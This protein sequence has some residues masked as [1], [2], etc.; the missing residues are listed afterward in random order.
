MQN[1]ETNIQALFMGGKLR[2]AGDY[3]S[4]L[5]MGMQLMAQMQQQ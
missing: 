3:S 1:G 2:M 5:Q 4:A